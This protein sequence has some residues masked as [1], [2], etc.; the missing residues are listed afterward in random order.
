MEDEYIILVKKTIKEFAKEFENNDEV[1]APLLWD[2]MKM[3]IRS[4][5]LNYGRKRKRDM[6][7]EEASVES[8]TLFLERKLEENNPPENTKTNLQKGSKAKIMER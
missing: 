3:H 6:K 4:T 1:D 7:S 5:S 8:D 2:T